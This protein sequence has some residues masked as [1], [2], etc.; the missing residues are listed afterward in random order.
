MCI[1][2]VRGFFRSNL[3]AAQ[4]VVLA[5]CPSWRFT[6]A[7]LQSSEGSTG[8]GRS[9]SKV[10]AS[11]GCRQEASALQTWA[12]PRGCWVSSWWGSWLP[13][14]S[15]SFLQIQ[16]RK[17]LVSNVTHHHFHC[18]LSARCRSL[19]PSHTQGGVIRLYLLKGGASKN[20]CSCS[21]AASIHTHHSHLGSSLVHRQHLWGAP[22]L[23][24][25]CCLLMGTHM[26]S[27]KIFIA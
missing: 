1:I 5:Q 4:L 12:S 19:S 17:D 11:H 15:F 27:F 25:D 2:F 21:K 16:A 9:T 22:T 20:F 23:W 13:S 18:I 10:A 8:A 3:G 24:K 26:T 7:R 14:A 6:Q